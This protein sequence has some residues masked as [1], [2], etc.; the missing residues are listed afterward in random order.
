MSEPRMP[1]GSGTGSWSSEQSLP[2]SEQGIR[3]ALR[4]AIRSTVTR[5]APIP[6]ESACLS[7]RCLLQALPST[8]RRRRAPSSEGTPSRSSAM[9]LRVS[10]PRIIRTCL[11]FPSAS[12]PSSLLTAASCVR[13]WKSTRT[14][15]RSAGSPAEPW[16]PIIRSKAREPIRFSQTGSQDVP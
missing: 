6:A 5:W 1:P 4:Q 8:F 13:A 2:D 15:S 12:R 9:P 14:E 11:S 7:L 3:C 16:F 10:R